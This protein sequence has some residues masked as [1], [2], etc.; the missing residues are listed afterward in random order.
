MSRSHLAF[1]YSVLEVGTVIKIKLIKRNLYIEN[2]CMFEF[3][4]IKRKLEC[5]AQI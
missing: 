4:V 2:F 3:C 5:E 1:N